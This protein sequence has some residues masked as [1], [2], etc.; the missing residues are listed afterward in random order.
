MKTPVVIFAIISMISSIIGLYSISTGLPLHLLLTTPS[1]SIKAAQADT[2]EE[3][4]AKHADPTY[5]CPMHSQ[6]VQ[7]EKGSCPICGM[8]LVLKDPP[9]A[10]TTTE[11]K[12][13]I[14]WVA[15][16]DANYRRDKPGKSPMGMDLVP[17][18]GDGQ[19]ANQDDEFP[20]VKVDASTAQNMGIRTHTVAR[21]I[22]NQTFRTIGRIQYNEN[23][24]QHVHPRASGWVEKAHIRAEGDRVKKGQVLLE[25]YA[26]DLVAAQQDYLL[27]KKSSGRYSGTGSASLLSSAKQRLALLNIPPWVI[28]KL[29]SSEEIRNRIPVLSPQE[30]VV[31]AMGIRD[32]MY[33]TPET[34]MYS[35]VDLSSVWVIVDIFEDQ[36]SWIKAGDRARI[37][38]EG[39]PGEEWN[40]VV[41]YIYPELDPSTRTVKVRLK[42][43][44][45]E[46]KLKPNMF[47]RVSIITQ[48][49]ET[50]NVPAEAVIY[51]ADKARVIKQN[52]KGA[53]QPVEVSLGI[54]SGG[55]IEILKGLEEGDNVVISGQF[56]LDSESNLQAS[57]RRL[58]E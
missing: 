30:G 1:E 20:T 23:S 41:D 48:S 42:F 15:P 50:L 49:K 4:V 35:I 47:S 3:H 27:S 36:M 17:V 8:D 19:G 34:E 31:L 57:F 26:P 40:G 33:V 12:N 2:L 45:P 24:L 37:T 53:F 32:G 10:E 6:I 25:Y 43:D 22:L 44:T 18:Y 13:I 7:N 56:L 29:D 51:Y 58:S 5:V 16:M 11:E 14:Y 52:Y 39:L 28:S 38:V 54:H 21:G 55:N 46:K 9:P